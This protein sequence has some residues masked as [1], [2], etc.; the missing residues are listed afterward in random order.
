MDCATPSAQATLIK[1][2]G[3]FFAVHVRL[4]ARHVTTP[5]CAHPAQLECKYLTER[6]YVRVPTTSTMELATAATTLAVLA[7]LASITTV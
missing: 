5:Q 2:L 3:H 4:T 1:S 6:A 7:Q